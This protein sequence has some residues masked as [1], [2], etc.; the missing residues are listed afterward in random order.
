MLAR[1]T[2]FEEPRVKI[3]VSGA[4][5]ILETGCEQLHGL[6]R[7]DV[8]VETPWR[9]HVGDGLPPQLH[10]KRDLSDLSKAQGARDRV[11]PSGDVL[12]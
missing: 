12:D 6:F 10:L 3:P 5:R 11:I 7:R 9:H 4:H 8:E 2:G 1:E